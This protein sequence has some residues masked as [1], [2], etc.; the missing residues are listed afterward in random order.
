MEPLVR[1]VW[2]GITLFISLPVLYIILPALLLYQVADAAGERDIRDNEAEIAAPDRLTRPL[3]NP[4][5]PVSGGCAGG[6]GDGG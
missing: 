3:G 2:D 6:N 5:L 4:R 1:W